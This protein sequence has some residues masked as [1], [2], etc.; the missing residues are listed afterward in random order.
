MIKFKPIF[1]VGIL[2]LSQNVMA[3][4]NDTATA[5]ING[6]VIASLEVGITNHLTLPDLVFPDAGETTS[7]ELTCPSNAVLY[8]SNGGNPFANG[9]LSETGVHTGSANKTP[10]NFAGVCANIA[11]SGEREYHYVVTTS[12]LVLPNTGISLDSINCGSD[13]NFTIVPVAFFALGTFSCGGK[14]I[15]DDTASAGTYNG[16]FEVA[17]VYD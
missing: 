4:N 16:S 11:V 12:T 2:V 5:T 1:S 13:S 15:V 7:V 6:E 17:V 8:D 14:I 10:G 9:D 3:D